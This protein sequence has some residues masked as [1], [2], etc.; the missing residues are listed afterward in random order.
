MN[1]LVQPTQGFTDCPKWLKKKYY[2]AV[3]YT[4]QLCNKKKSLEPHRIKRGNTGGLYTVYPLN[5]QL[6]N[7]KIVCKECHKLLHAKEF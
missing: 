5:H 7:V 6:N 4:C 3:N 1:T 2:E